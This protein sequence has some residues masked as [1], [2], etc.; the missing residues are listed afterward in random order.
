VAIVSW[1]EAGR[2]ERVLDAVLG[3]GVD[4]DAVALALHCPG[5]AVEELARRRS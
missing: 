5:G 4:R 1:Q 3:T 2:G